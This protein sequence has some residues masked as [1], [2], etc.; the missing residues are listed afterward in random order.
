MKV[1]ANFTHEEHPDAQAA[2]APDQGIKGEA[3]H[4]LEIGWIHIW[5]SDLSGCD[6][7]QRMQRVPGQDR[8]GSRHRC[9]EDGEQN[10]S[11]QC[12]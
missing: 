4:I 6:G 10:T 2:V 8:Q 11:W 9:A 5:E 1:G 12:R 7:Q 3:Q